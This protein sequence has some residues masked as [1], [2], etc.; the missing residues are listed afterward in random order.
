MSPKD[1][2]HFLVVYRVAGGTAE[3]SE[4]AND[5]YEGALDAYRAT[6]ELHSADS[7]VEVLLLSADS[8]DSLMATHGRFFEQSRRHVDDY[9]TARLDELL[10]EAER[11]PA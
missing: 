4:Y 3:V 5:Q 9:I 1:L 7:G 11:A 6:E 8:L 2:R 10:D